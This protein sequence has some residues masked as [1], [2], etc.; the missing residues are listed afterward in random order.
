MDEDEDNMLAF[1]RDDFAVASNPKSPGRL[2][3][4]TGPILSNGKIAT[5]PIVCDGRARIVDIAV[6]HPHNGRPTTHDIILRNTTWTLVSSTTHQEID[7]RLLTSTLEWQKGVYEAEFEIGDGTTLDDRLKVRCFCHRRYRNCV[8]TTVDGTYATLTQTTPIELKQTWGLGLVGVGAPFHSRSYV[9]PVRKKG[10][11]D[12]TETHVTIIETTFDGKSTRIDGSYDDIVH[13]V[14]TV[15][16][17]ASSGVV[18]SAARTTDIDLTVQTVNGGMSPPQHG[19]GVPNQRRRITI[20]TFVGSSFDTHFSDPD[21]LR[22][23]METMNALFDRHGANVDDMEDA[24]VDAMLRSMWQHTNV[25]IPLGDSDSRFKRA[26]CRAV[27]S[28]NTSLCK[29]HDGFLYRGMSYQPLS[30]TSHSSQ[31]IMKVGAARVSIDWFITN[32][33]VT[34][35]HPQTARWVI[36]SRFRIVRDRHSLERIANASSLLLYIV[37]QDDEVEHAMLATHAWMY[38]RGSRDH[39]WFFSIGVDILRTAADL[40]AYEVLDRGVHVQWD[41]TTTFIVASAL[42]AACRGL[43]STRGHNGVDRWRPALDITM[44][45]IKTMIL[46]RSFAADD[47]ILYTPLFRRWL[48]SRAVGIDDASAWHDILQRRLDALPDVPVDDLASSST[49][50]YHMW[51]RCLIL[52]QLCQTSSTQSAPSRKIA[53]QKALDAFLDSS[54]LYTGTHDPWSTS[55]TVSEPTWCCMLIGIVLLG[56]CGAY[57]DGHIDIDTMKS[58]Q[59]RPRA[60]LSLYPFRVCD[61]ESTVNMPSDEWGDVIRLVSRGGVREIRSRTISRSKLLYLT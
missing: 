43:M 32:T 16:I 39:D 45:R 4:S 25:S 57:V 55:V 5:R 28:L 22:L 56:V 31:D 52:G 15:Y 34:L 2:V 19:G 3:D 26:L 58:Y 17:G 44:A 7:I 54:T 9:R 41:V 46:T 47:G 61:I 11:D 6:S 27:Y 35:M 29:E 40:L 36:E 59:R 37:G 42:D 60:D 24:H 33:I 48:M 13:S 10:A 38:Y 50:I 49:M 18:S 8:V 51:H 14:V 12:D 21:P 20:L 30:S 23:V 1:E 53:F